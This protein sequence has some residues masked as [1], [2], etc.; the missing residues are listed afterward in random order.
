MNIFKFI[1]YDTIIMAKVT[2]LING[3]SGYKTTK[4]KIILNSIEGYNT[5][6]GCLNG[7]DSVKKHLVH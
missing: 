6:Q 5:R 7:I 1:N 3:A 2:G 4:M